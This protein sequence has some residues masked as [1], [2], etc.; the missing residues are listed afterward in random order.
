[1]I[2]LIL[3]Y[4]NIHLQFIFKILLN[5]FIG[6]LDIDGTESALEKEMRK[7]KA[8][9]LAVEHKAKQE[10]MQR[11]QEKRRQKE[12]QLA[13]EHKAKQE[14]LQRQQEKQRQ[15]EIQLAAEKS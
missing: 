7:Q 13:A 6:I 14:K 5:V 2:D 10:E 9:Q 4:F 3:R 15:K 8:I 12:I 11:Q 1:M